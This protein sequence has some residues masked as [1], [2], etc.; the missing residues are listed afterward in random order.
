MISKTSPGIVGS[1]AV[2]A[3]QFVFLATTCCM[4]AN[5][6]FGQSDL[7]LKAQN[8]AENQQ[9]DSA[10]KYY[11]LLAQSNLQAGEVVDYVYNYIDAAFLYTSDGQYQ[12]AVSVLEEARQQLSTPAF[13]PH[14]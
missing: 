9:A 4:L 12:Q 13:G 5:P 7:E 2:K 10:L 6:L 11:R 1:Q 3:W 14:L 8:F